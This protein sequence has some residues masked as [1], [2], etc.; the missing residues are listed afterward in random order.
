[1]LSGVTS[2][3]FIAHGVAVRV[4]VG[5][6]VKPLGVPCVGVGVRVAGVRVPVGVLT[7][8]VLLAGVG[9]RVAIGP[10]AI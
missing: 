8:V 7:G 5:V 2:E 1:M 6:E 9:V 3:T 4:L 10:D